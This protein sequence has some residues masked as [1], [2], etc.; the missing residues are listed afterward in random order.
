MVAEQNAPAISY[1]LEDVSRE[2]IAIYSKD[3]NADPEDPCIKPLYLFHIAPVRR[4]RHQ[5][6]SKHQI[7]PRPQIGHEN[8]EASSKTLH[9]G[10]KRSAGVAN[11]NEE[12]VALVSSTKKHK[13]ISSLEI[14]VHG[15]TVRTTYPEVGSPLLVKAFIVEEQSPEAINNVNTHARVIYSDE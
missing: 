11:I 10:S 14:T 4:W 3:T 6:V 5:I 2:N 1:D 13:S 8:R 9:T 15:C 12:D 7:V